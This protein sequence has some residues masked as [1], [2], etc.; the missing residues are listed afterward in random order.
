MVLAALTLLSDWKFGF[1]STK[2]Y[3]GAVVTLYTLLNGVLTYRIWFYEHG[4]V[5]EGQLKGQKV[6]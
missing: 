1:E 3:T 2:W 5:Y 6:G 4:V